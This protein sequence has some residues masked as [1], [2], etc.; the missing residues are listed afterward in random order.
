MALIL[1]KQEFLINDKVILKDK[2]T[3]E[4]LY[5]LDIKLNEEEVSYV[6]KLI[7]KEC[8]DGKQKN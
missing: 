6:R 7:D 4:V 1:T 2:E 8:N 5:E 3:K